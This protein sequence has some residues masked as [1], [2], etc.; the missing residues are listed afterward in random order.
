MDSRPGCQQHGYSYFSSGSY[1]QRAGNY[2]FTDATHPTGANQYTTYHPGTQRRTSQHPGPNQQFPQPAN[3]FLTNQMGMTFQPTQYPA[4]NPN[5]QQHPGSNQYSTLNT[6]SQQFQR[7]PFQFPGPPLFTPYFG[8]IQLPGNNQ[9]FEERRPHTAG[10][11]FIFQQATTSGNV[12]QTWGNNLHRRQRQKN[13]FAP[14]SFFGQ[15]EKMETNEEKKQQNKEEIQA[16]EARQKEKERIAKTSHIKRLIT[17]YAK[18]RT[19]ERLCR[20]FETPVFGDFPGNETEKTIV[21]NLAHFLKEQI[22]KIK[23][24]DRE[25]RGKALF[26][27]GDPVLRGPIFVIANTIHELENKRGK[28]EKEKK[29]FDNLDKEVKNCA[30]ELEE[31]TKEAEIL[32]T[33]VEAYH[34][35]MKAMKERKIAERKSNDTERAQHG[36]EMEEINK[37]HAHNLHENLRNLQEK[38]GKETK[39]LNETKRELENMKKQNDS[40]RARIFE[41]MAQNEDF[42]KLLVKP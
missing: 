23:H 31:K 35:R 3:P 19:L 9:P 37:T 40:I 33:E 17:S 29:Y 26:I 12:R 5:T 16:E 41:T 4:T 13:G 7:A 2:N 25:E 32:K 36:R 6:G 14:S 30:G 34:T 18:V 22:N 27:N 11:Q 10:P 1:S 15:D 8:P 21:K 20:D 38:I 42:R 24:V 39:A 28:L